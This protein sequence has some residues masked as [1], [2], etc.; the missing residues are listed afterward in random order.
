MSPAAC[1]R[2]RLVAYVTEELL[3]DEPIDAEEPLLADGV[4][5]SL[6]M[7]RLVAFIEEAYDISIPPEHFTIEN[8]RTIAAIAEYLNGNYDTAASEDRE[9]ELL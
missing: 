4:V 2:A 7:M 5:D 1:T 3:N 9:Q 6:G 8:F